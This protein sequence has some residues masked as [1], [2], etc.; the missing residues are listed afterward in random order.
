MPDRLFSR[1][2]FSRAALQ[3]FAVAIASPH[4]QK[5][6]ENR[7]AVPAPEGSIHLNFNENNYGPSPKA[8]AALDACTHIASRYPFSSYEEVAGII[9]RV[10]GVKRDNVILGCG[11]TEILRVSDAAFLGPGKILVIADPTFEAVFEYAGVDHAETVRVPLTTD[12]RHDLPR[13]A[14][15]C[16]SKTGVVYVCNPNNPTATI[17][18]RDEFADFV[19]RVPASTLILVDEA[20]FDFADDPRY[21]SAIEFISK[22]PNV[23]VARTFSKIYG[24]AGMRLGFALGAQPT[25]AVLRE[26]LDQDNANAAVLSAAV[27]SLSDTDYIAA[28]REKFISTRRWLCN[29]LTKD[30][31]SFADSQAN[32]LMID[33]GGDVSPVIEKFRERKILVGRRFPSM[34]HWMR[35]TIGKQS[36]MDAFL[37]ALR[38]IVPA[39]ANNSS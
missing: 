24:L 3:S 4:L 32:F 1:R 7:H 25:I 39:P 34:P 38:E 26:C 21:S 18:T 17:V 37:A 16:T 5:H 19:T 36:E 30:G 33:V 20:Y 35:V 9:A 2:D 10:H 29:E 11:S 27:A 31:R 28:C 22:Y 23:V 12:H 8:A 14:A 15:A 13:M 6:P